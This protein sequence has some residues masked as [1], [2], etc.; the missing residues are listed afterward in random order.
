[1]F[2]TNEPTMFTCLFG[3]NK[4]SVFIG[5]FNNKHANYI[6]RICINQV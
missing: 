3:K 4:K 2:F 6:R 1:M 5:R